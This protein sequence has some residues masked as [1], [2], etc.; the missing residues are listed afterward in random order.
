MSR[1]DPIAAYHEAAHA[2]LASGTG[3]D[4]REVVLHPIGVRADEAGH[5]ALLAW[6]DEMR[7][8]PVEFLVQLLGG[9]AA[10]QR[11]C[12]YKSARCV[13]DLETAV[14]IAAEI[15]HDGAD[16]GSARVQATL[17]AAAAIADARMYTASVWAAV[18]RIARALSVKRRLAGRDVQ[19][20]LREA[21]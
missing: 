9:A 8:H 13:Q 20:L 14:D 12:G 15:I 5:C 4:I 1:V 11:L 3:F 7:N 17:R 2:V 18:E 16:A 19:L 6:E 21:R 10:E